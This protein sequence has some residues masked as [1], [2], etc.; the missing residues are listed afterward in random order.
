MKVDALFDDVQKLMR[1]SRWVLKVGFRPFRPALL[2][3][4][5]HAE[6]S[7]LRWLCWWG[8]GLFLVC[9]VGL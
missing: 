6:Q 3:D 7:Q 4:S 1:L 8:R 2:V 5:A 9:Q